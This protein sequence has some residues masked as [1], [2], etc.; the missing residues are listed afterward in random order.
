MWIVNEYL[1]CLFLI[2]SG[3]FIWGWVFA[4][5]RLPWKGRVWLKWLLLVL[6]SFIG[7]WHLIFGI[8]KTFYVTLGLFV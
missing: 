7:S 1:C 5:Q 6:A 8:L 2:L 3:L 4:R